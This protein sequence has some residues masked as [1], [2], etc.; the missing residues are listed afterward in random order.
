ML[1]RSYFAARMTLFFCGAE[2]HIR[3]PMS[4]QCK[5]SLQS[6]CCLAYNGDTTS[7][8]TLDVREWRHIA[9]NLPL[10]GGKFVSCSSSR[11]TWVIMDVLS[12][13]PKYAAC[14]LQIFCYSNKRVKFAINYKVSGSLTASLRVHVKKF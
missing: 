13:D 9:I 2:P 7:P 12:I 14:R 4:L 10:S 8:F 3:L 5:K 1:A 6:A 11:L